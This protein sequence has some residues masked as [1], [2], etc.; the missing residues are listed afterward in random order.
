M[1]A[2]PSLRERKKGR[3]LQVGKEN[4]TS[5]NENNNIKIK[6][7][8]LYKKKIMNSTLMTVTSPLQLMLGAG[9]G[10]VPDWS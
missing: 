10:V 8:Q 5:F 6:Y 9:I 7:I 4:G 1:D 2:L 3:N